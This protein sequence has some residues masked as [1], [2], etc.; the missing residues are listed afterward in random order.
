MYHFI[1]RVGDKYG[2][3]DSNDGVIDWVSQDELRTYL[4]QGTEV[5]GA[6]ADMKELV[7]QVVMLHPNLCNWLP[8][9]GNIFSNA[10]KFMLYDNGRFVLKADGKQFKGFVRR[11]DAHTS[12]LQ[13]NYNVRVPMRTANYDKMLT[14]T[15]D[16]IMELF[17]KIATPN[18]PESTLDQDDYDTVHAYEV[19][20]YRI[21]ADG[22]R[23][24]E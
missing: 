14:S 19:R 18:I 5:K 24:P 7:P 2:V 9:H 4:A 12:M 6:S 23:W 13:F 11:L 3:L 20:P 8:E 17:K 15:Q 1:K 21:K 16:D 22:P 10:K